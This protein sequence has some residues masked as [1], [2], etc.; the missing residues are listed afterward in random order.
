MPRF[1]SDKKKAPRFR[2]ALQGPAR[3]AKISKP[4]FIYVPEQRRL[5]FSERY[6]VERRVRSICRLSEVQVSRVNLPPA[7]AKTNREDCEYTLLK[8]LV[9]LSSL[10]ISGYLYC[11]RQYT[12]ADALHICKNYGDG[13]DT[14][15]RQVQAHEKAH[16]APYS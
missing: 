9:Q 1:P 2:G 14:S 10:L 6:Y 13:A 3:R 4:V 8:D 7:W 15:G 5:A 11:S 12:L 16:S